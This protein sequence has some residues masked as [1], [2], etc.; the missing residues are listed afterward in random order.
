MTR[1]ATIRDLFPTQ[2][3]THWGRTVSTLGALAVAF[4]SAAS[5]APLQCGEDSFENNDTCATAHLISAPFSASGLAVYKSDSDYFTI[6][7]P[8]GQEIQI[9]AFFSH[10]TADVDLFLYDLNGP[11]GGLLDNLS[12]SVS[13]TNDESI[14]WHNNGNAP[15]EVAM[16]VLVFPGSIAD[17][18]NY[19]L[20]VTMGVPFE[21]CDPSASDDSFEDNDSCAA[22]ISAP[23]GVTP[24]LWASNQDRDF[25]SFTVQPGEAVDAQIFFSD[26]V[27]DLD[28][29]LWDAA[30]PC[31]GG[32]GSGELAAGF[33]QT[34]NERI[35][36]SN[37]GSMARTLVLEVYAFSNSDC[38]N[39]DLSIDFAGGGIGTNYCVAAPNSTG[40]ISL[41]SAAGNTSVSQNDLRLSAKQLPQDSFG[42]FLASQTQSF[43]TN[44]GGSQGNLCLGGSIGRFNEMIQNT[45]G[46]GRLDINVD[47]NAV[48]QPDGPVPASSGETWHFQVWHR[49]TSPTGASSSNFTNGILL[50]LTN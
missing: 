7:V 2:R 18:N 47:L 27:A 32:F 12:T 26:S 3:R 22:A 31:G 8:P 29:I 24:G 6:T 19:D 5:A 10:S 34:D 13:S 38:N 20:Q 23:I 17:C 48:P 14:N 42:F 28:M 21:P 39:Y 50:V 4:G 45:G 46:S 37:T 9:D 16:K 44:P 25:W 41:I 11:C 33:S 43:V 35:I 40:V 15:V 30:G 1:S 36:W 49:D